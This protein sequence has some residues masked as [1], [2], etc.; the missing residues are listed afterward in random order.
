MSASP[1][2]E[3]P[4]IAAG[5]VLWRPTRR[6][7]EV[8]LIHRPRYD[9][10]T[11]PKG[12]VEP[13]EH[14]VVGGL[15]EIVEETGFTARLVREVTR[16][17]YEVPRRPRHGPGGESAHKRVHY[18]SALALG[19]EFTPNEE[20]D[21]LRW[22]SIDDAAATLTY[23]LDRRVLLR[24]AAQPTS[25]NTLIIVRHAKAGRK[26]GYRGE[27]LLRPL[28]RGGRA[29]AESLVEMLSAFGPGR[30]L[31]APP[32]RCRQTLE[33]LAVESGLP[34]TEAGAFAEDGYAPKP[35]LAQARGLAV[36]GERTGTVPVICS[37]GGVIPDLT[38]GWAQADGAVLTPARNRKA[39]TW[40]ITT[41]G[42]RMLTADHI[43]SPLPLES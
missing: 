26:Q 27:D 31:S 9:D 25:A 11:L 28:D 19:G 30:L 17:T 5:G 3:R 20:S 38:S 33:P 8:A 2:S 29:Q 6:G 10:W 7:P 22:R 34:I 37:Q 21:A 40:V 43:P 42:G 18:W 36:E 15:R 32:V 39:S 13:G 1:V 23:A 4:V 41:E 35:A 12:H 16:V 14:L 24:Y